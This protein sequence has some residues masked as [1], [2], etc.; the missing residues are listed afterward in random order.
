MTKNSIVTN[1]L[2]EAPIG[3]TIKTNMS[4]TEPSC[5]HNSKRNE[6]LSGK[7]PNPDEWFSVDLFNGC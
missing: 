3:V 5:Q 6:G 2:V 4:P 1:H 7:T